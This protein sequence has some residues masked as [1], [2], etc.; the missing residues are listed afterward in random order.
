M[1]SS[2]MV[3]RIWRGNAPLG[4]GVF[5]SR[6]QVLTCN[7]V[8]E[9]AEGEDIRV[10]VAGSGAGSRVKKVSRPAPR[11]GPRDDLALLE[12]E[13]ALEEAEIL[14]WDEAAVG[15]DQP[16]VFHGFRNALPQAALESVPTHLVSHDPVDG[17]D[18]LQ[19]DVTQGFSGGPVTRAR[20]GRD[21]LVGITVE[22]LNL[23]PRRTVMIPAVPVVAFLRAEGV[24][25]SAAPHGAPP[26]PVVRTLSRQVVVRMHPS[27]RDLVPDGVNAVDFKMIETPTGPWQV[28]EGPDSPAWR[29]TLANVEAVCASV[30]AVTPSEIHFVGQCPYSLASV[31]GNRILNQPGNVLVVHQGSGEAKTLQAWRPLA[32]GSAGFLVEE[33]TPD[34]PV[35]PSAVHLYLEVARPIDP[36]EIPQALKMGSVLTVRLRVPSFGQTAIPDPQAAARAAADLASLVDRLAASHPAAPVH[37]FVAGPVGL[38]MLAARRWH[39]LPAAGYGPRLIIH[40]R[41]AQ[42]DR[43][44]FWPAITWRTGT[45]YSARQPALI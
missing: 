35:E 7:H 32:S 14:D 39:L 30:Q 22:Q 16:V 33:R 40:E 41:H 8:V 38:V 21:W 43:A 37:L 24:S 26:S 2:L 29:T 19:D 23:S 3:A 42:G 5:V 11:G 13:R 18:W 31:F 9:A 36:N 10:H 27:A 17:V 45:L 28:L 34:A 4:A 20:D 15:G 12:L 6:T 1:A 25:L 44:Q